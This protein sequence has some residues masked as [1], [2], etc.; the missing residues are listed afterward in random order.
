MHQS[1]L[2]YTLHFHAGAI[3]R[4]EEQRHWN[5]LFSDP[6]ADQRRA[7]S[8]YPRPRTGA[9]ASGMFPRIFAITW[10]GET[11]CRCSA[12][13]TLRSLKSS[14]TPGWLA[15]GRN[16]REAALKHAD[17]WHSTLGSS[18]EALAALIRQ[19]AVDILVDLTQHMAGNRLPVFARE[20]A[21]G[22]GEFRRV[23]R[24]ARGWTGFDT[25]SATGGLQGRSSEFGSSEIGCETRVRSPISG[26]RPSG[27]RSGPPRQ[28]LESYESACG[29]EV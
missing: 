8:E 14:A 10:W 18:R 17:Q 25:E 26:L 13:T 11:S 20:P 9:C 19:D 12:I 1:N 5:R 4:S 15:P 21:P 23:S 29:L 28:L 6:V 22:S 2:I 3:K 7:A 27:P 24:K 16:N